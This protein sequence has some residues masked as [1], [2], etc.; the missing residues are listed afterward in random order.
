MTSMA[1]L[2]LPAPRESGGVIVMFLFALLPLVMVVGAF[3]STMLGR[4]GRL[5]AD[6]ADEHALLAAES[7]IDEALFRARNAALA[8]GVG[9]SRQL[10]AGLS[11]RVTPTLLNLDGLDNDG[12]GASD[13]ADEEVFQLIIVGSCRDRQRRLAA[14]LGRSVTIASVPGALMTM[15]SKIAINLD[16][17]AKLD[18]N[19]HRINGLPKVAAPA[20]AGIAVGP[21]GDVADLDAELTGTERLRVLGSG[22]LP[23]LATMPPFPYDELVAIGRSSASLVL[24]NGHYSDLQFGSAPAATSIVTYREG[25][26]RLSGHSRGC[27]VLIVNGDLAIDGTFRFDGVIVVTGS[28]DTGVGTV[29]VYGGLI[30]GPASSKFDFRGTA[31]LR[32]STEALAFANKITASYV[33]FNGWQ[34]LSRR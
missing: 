11:F 18:G 5:N 15:S 19:D 12:D 34:E 2:T 33:E 7:G 3:G 31:D 28:I 24:T 20:S 10:D 26:L 25:N 22:G 16:G 8:S 6:I 4:S 23:S 29:Q 13:E 14:Y 1:A 21:D 17:T 9:F 30:M 27:G 32:Y